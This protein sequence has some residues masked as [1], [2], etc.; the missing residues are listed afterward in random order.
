MHIESRR[1]DLFVRAKQTSL[2]L[3]PGER[4]QS[5]RSASLPQLFS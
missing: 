1:A 3:A 5:S 2:L 4:T